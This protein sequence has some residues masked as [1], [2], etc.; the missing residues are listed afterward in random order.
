MNLNLPNP[1]DS[2]D[3][4]SRNTARRGKIASLP[5]LVREEL[6]HRLER[7]DLGESI[8]AWLNDLPEAQWLIR[9]RWPGQPITQQNLSVW[10]LGG[11]QEWLQGHMDRAEIQVLQHDAYG[12]EDQPEA[13]SLA[14]RLANRLTLQVIHI[15][16][17]IDKM[18]EL[19]GPN[20]EST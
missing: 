9:H 16:C 17:E 8:L 12:L 10:R 7:G 20:G 3:G 2:N 14:D 19:A 4:P 6:N 15:M 5:F 11:Y 13:T 18:L 1:I